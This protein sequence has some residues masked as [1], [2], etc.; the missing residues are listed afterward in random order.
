MLNPLACLYHSFIELSVDFLER[1]NMKRMATASLQT[2][3]SMF[4]NSR[5][6]PRS[7]IENVIVVRRTEMVFSMKLTPVSRA[8]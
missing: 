5:W 3:G 6:P 1:S 8:R 4:T 2:S 7:H